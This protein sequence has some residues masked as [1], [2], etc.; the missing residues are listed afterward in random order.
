MSHKEINAR[1]GADPAYTA[2]VENFMRL[3]DPVVAA[4]LASRIPNH[5]SSRVP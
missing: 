3:L 1:L 4:T 5:V 2:E